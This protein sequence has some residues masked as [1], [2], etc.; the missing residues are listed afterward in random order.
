M[1]LHLIVGRKLTKNNTS[2]TQYA[3]TAFYEKIR[4]RYTVRVGG[5][6]TNTRVYKKNCRSLRMLLKQTSTTKEHRDLNRRN[7]P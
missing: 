4:G 2:I 7:T 5:S 6:N 1:D 3:S